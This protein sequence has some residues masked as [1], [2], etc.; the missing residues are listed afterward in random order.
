MPSAHSPVYVSISSN[1]LDDL[2]HRNKSTLIHR[3]FS[4]NPI[5]T[6]NRGTQLVELLQTQSSLDWMSN[7]KK[8][9]KLSKYYHILQKYRTRLN[10]F[11]YD[12]DDFLPTC[13]DVLW[14]KSAQGLPKYITLD[15]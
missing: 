5:Q 8:T 1:R 7:Y 13:P 4:V 2:A 10:K 11:C 3:N 12:I 6:F 14:K 9:V 15:K